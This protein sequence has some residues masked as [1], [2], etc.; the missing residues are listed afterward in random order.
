[1]RLSTMFVI[2]ASPAVLDTLTRRL[3]G[4]SRTLLADDGSFRCGSLTV[5]A[6]ISFAESTW[7]RLMNRGSLSVPFM[8]TLLIMQTRGFMLLASLV[9]LEMQRISSPSVAVTFSSLLSQRE[10]FTGFTGLFELCIGCRKAKGD[11]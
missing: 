10:I 7:R 4:R 11:R 3:V 9:I 6:A 1:M 8:N 2:A 5:E